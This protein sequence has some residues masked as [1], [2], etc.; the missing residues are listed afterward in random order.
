MVDV[1]FGL[2]LYKE[3][4]FGWSKNVW[5]KI[6]IVK[7]SNWMKYKNY[8]CQ[9]PLNYL[10]LFGLSIKIEKNFSPLNQ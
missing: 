10:T 8:V 1:D 5:F 6:F 7:V 9:K 4:I 2:D 3:M